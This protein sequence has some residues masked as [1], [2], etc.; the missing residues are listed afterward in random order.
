MQVAELQG[1]KPMGR[2]GDYFSGRSRMR[3]QMPTDFESVL[4]GGP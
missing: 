4:G 2:L 3:L 1:R